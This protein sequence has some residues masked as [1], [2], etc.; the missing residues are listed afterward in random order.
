MLSLLFCQYFTIQ[1]LIQLGTLVEINQ[2]SEIFL[3]KSLSI[4]TYIPLEK[5]GPIQWR[6]CPFS[7]ASLSQP[8]W[9]Q[10]S[11]DEGEEEKK[12]VANCAD[13]PSA[14]NNFV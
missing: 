10:A 8:L 12:L 9:A 4:E 1:F 6:A 14:E 5:Q 13:P 7:V 3:K 2:Q 11:P